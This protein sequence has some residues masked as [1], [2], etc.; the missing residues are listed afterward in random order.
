MK[1]TIKEINGRFTCW[2]CGH[3]WSA[4]CGDNEVPEYCSC[5]MPDSID[6]VNFKNHT[7][8][9][10]IQIILATENQNLLPLVGWI[11]DSI[12]YEKACEKIRV[13]IADAERG[14]EMARKPE[15]LRTN[16]I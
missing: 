1:K 3:E 7:R 11:S 4:M 9:E 10:A 12:E 2:A 14:S 15:K 5:Q 16:A 13:A 6:H 8:Q